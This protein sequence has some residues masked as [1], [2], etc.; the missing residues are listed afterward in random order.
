MKLPNA[1]H[2]CRPWRIHELV[3]DFTLEDYWALPTPGGP[4]GLQELL[5]LSS[6]FDPSTFESGPTRVL[7]NLRDLLGRW[8]DL[9]EIS[10]SVE[11]DE[12]GMPIPGCTETSLRDRLPP[13]LRGT[14]EDFTFNSLPFIPVYR[15]DREAVAEI[16]NKTVHAVAHLSWVEVGEGGYEGR[17]AVYVKPRGPFGKAYMALI[18]PFRYWIVYPALMKQMERMWDTRERDAVSP[19]VS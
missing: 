3:P 16:S 4:D 5:D 12:A 8:F 14:A 13:D 10:A 11:G 1:E 15:T 6:S 18:K 17:M 9:G 2:E 7:W 19:G